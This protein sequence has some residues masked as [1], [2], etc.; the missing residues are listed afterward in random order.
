VPILNPGQEIRLKA[1]ISGRSAT[2]PEFRF[3]SKAEQPIRAVETDLFTRAVRHERGIV[4]FLVVLAVLL[5]ILC[6]VVMEPEE[7]WK[8]DKLRVALVRNR[9]EARELS[10]RS[11]VAVKPGEDSS[12]SDQSAR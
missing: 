4:A 5:A 10:E 7:Y 2:S 9:M 11:A 6:V 1:R 8:P 3:W 12:K